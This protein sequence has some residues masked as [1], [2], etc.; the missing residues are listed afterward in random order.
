VWLTIDCFSFIQAIPDQAESFFLK[1]P[2][3][4]PSLL[5]SAD[6]QDIMLKL[7]PIRIRCFSYHQAGSSN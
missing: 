4:D 3:V 5:V 6:N 7:K 2:V 1:F